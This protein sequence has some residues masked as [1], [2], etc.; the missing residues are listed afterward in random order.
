MQPVLV[1]YIESLDGVRQVNDLAEVANALTSVNRIVSLVS[2][3]IIGILV[4]VAGIFI[5]TT[6]STGI[7]VRR[8]EIS[9]MKLIGAT[10][11]FIQAPFLVE[12]FVLGAAG[13]LIPIVFLYFSYAKVMNYL[14]VNYGSS[15]GTSISL[16]TTHTVFVKLIPLCF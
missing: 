14:T 5:S 3:V 2:T 8:T 15:L 13:A 6:I 11:T 4:L 1:R 16:L 12:G 7:T 10:D 9:I